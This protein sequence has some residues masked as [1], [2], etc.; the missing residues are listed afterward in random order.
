LSSIYNN[1]AKSWRRG[2]SCV[3]E[4]VNTR[5]GLLTTGAFKSSYHT[6][7]NISAAAGAVIKWRVGIT[8][9]YELHFLEKNIK[10]PTYISTELTR[11]ISR[12]YT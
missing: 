12:L 11:T 7:I 9:K 1:E 3:A 2:N 5:Q 8:I 10:I 4:V 6:V